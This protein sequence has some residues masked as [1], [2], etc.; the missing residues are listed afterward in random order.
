[1]R[2]EPNSTLLNSRSFQLI[3]IYNLKIFSNAKFASSVT[4]MAL[5]VDYN[6]PD[7]MHKNFKTSIS[8]FTNLKSILFC[9][10]NENPHHDLETLEWALTLTHT[11]TEGLFNSVETCLIW[12]ERLEFVESLGISI[13]PSIPHF[14]SLEKNLYKTTQW[15]FKFTSED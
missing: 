2:H 7:Y 14:D 12:K 10:Y 8:K 11:K 6:D 5:C 13:I 4:H 1:M 15:G 9:A 3:W